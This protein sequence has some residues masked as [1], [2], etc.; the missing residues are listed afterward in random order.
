MFAPNRVQF[1]KKRTTSEGVEDTGE[2]SPLVFYDEGAKNPH[3]QHENLGY[4]RRAEC[5][6]NAGNAY[7]RVRNASHVERKYPQWPL[8]PM[9]VIMTAM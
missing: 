3:I 7:A 1:K 4:A 6:G 5:V 8:S 9:A 2:D